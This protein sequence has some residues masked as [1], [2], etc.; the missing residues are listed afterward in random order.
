MIKE[1]IITVACHKGGVAKSQTVIEMAYYLARKRNSVLV[2]DVDPQ[3]NASDILMANNQLHCRT[4][5]DILFD[6]DAV[7]REDIMTRKFDTCS[8]DFV[9][10]SIASARLEGRITATPK[11]FVLADALAEMREKYDYIIIDTP[12]SAEL[13]SLCALIASDEVIIPVS[14][15]KPSIDGVDSIIRT[16]DAIRKNTRL[17][18]NL[19]VAG[20]LITRYRIAL[21]T[22]KGIRVLKEKYG[23]LVIEQPIRECTKVQQ[24]VD[25]CCP[26]LD[27]DP[28]CNA[29]KDYCHAFDKLF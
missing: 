9:C 12:P 18:P 8:I 24:A 20:I 2:V 13:L 6:G 14:P 17:N 28:G 3:A 16:I 23:R 11:E 10:S 26:V 5:A 15:D 21:S 4:I 1:K 25:S 19:Q 27:Y 7:Q 22:L 29:A